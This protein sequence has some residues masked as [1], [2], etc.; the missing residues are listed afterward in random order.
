MRPVAELRMRLF[1]II[2]GCLIGSSFAGSTA[3]DAVKLLPKEQRARVARI[4]ARE[5]SPE[6]QRW[7]L[8]VHDRGA[9]NGLKEFVV[10]DGAIVAERGISQFA[11]SLTPEQVIGDAVRF[12]S[13]RAAQLL[14]QYAE[15]NGVKAGRIAY[16]LR[17]DGPTAVPLW[18][19]T[20]HDPR[21]REL[22]SLT[23]TGTKGVVISHQG[24]TIEPAPVV[25]EKLREKLRPA[26]VAP[27]VREPTVQPAREPEPLPPPPPP[28]KP[29]V[30]RRLF[31]GGKPTPPP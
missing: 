19:L 6:P 1:F 28:K 24:F 11:E 23:I 18:R 12:D 2:S 20:C 22:G 31:G 27:V 7:Y 5:G 26:P 14:Q 13:N 8:L 4:E 30:I 17:K 3:L 10:A 16:Q 21:G 15:M 29:N 9:E 25:A